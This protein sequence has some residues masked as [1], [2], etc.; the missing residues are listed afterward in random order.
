[1]NNVPQELTQFI[2][3]TSKFG[4]AYPPL[5]WRLRYGDE[6]VNMQGGDT[7]RTQLS[8]KTARISSLQH[9][10]TTSSK[11]ALNS[12]SESGFTDLSVAMYWMFT[13]GSSRSFS[14][15]VLDDS[16]VSWTRGVSDTIGDCTLDSDPG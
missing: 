9:D 11:N 4:K 8:S 6:C 3:A 14:G 1:M 16:K 12:L 10:A 5:V 2:R 15:I 7:R 13:G